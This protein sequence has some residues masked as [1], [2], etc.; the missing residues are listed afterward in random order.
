MKKKNK[1]IQKGQVLIPAAYTNPPEPHEVA[2]AWIL[3]LHYGCKIEFLIPVDDYKRKT[4]DIAMLNLEWEIKSPM[5]KSKN[6][7]ARQLMRAS[8]QSKNII[9]D[10]RRTSISDADIE[11]TIRFELTKRQSIEKILFITK[12]GAVVEIIHKM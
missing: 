3:A 8:K 11:R 12:S 6:T 1:K 4:P 2:V 10:G 7:I 9:F 5:G